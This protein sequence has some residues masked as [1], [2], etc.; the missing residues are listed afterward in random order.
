MR[1]LIF[2]NRDLASNYILNLLLPHLAL[3]HE[4][5]VFLS[6]KVGKSTVAP[7]ALRTLKFLEQELPMGIL[8]PE[9]DKQVRP[10]KGQL[11][12]FSELSRHYKVDITS[13]NDIKSEEQIQYF[14]GL[15]P[16]LVLSIRYGKIFGK[17]F[18]SIPKYGVINLHSGILPNYRG[19]LAVFRALMNGDT[20]IGATLHYIDDHTI[21]TGGV[22]GFSQ[23][24]VQ[25]D[26]SLL[27]H[28][29]HLYPA[30]VDLVL[31]A[32]EKINSG[33]RPDTHQQNTEN[34]AYFTFPTPEEIAVFEA[35]GWELVGWDDYNTFILKYINDSVQD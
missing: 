17:S 4:I 31:D 9:L 6:D 32:I 3:Q 7:K 27:W 5:S 18:L 34:A 28:I 14:G 1:L 35:K 30:S 10:N 29:L 21:D 20:T 16:D 19:V 26:K 22:I 13:C 23:M 25:R 2:S 11:L 33:I 15:A 24:A 8:F 12:T